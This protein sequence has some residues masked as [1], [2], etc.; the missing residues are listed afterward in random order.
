M[1]PQALFPHGSTVVF[2]HRILDRI[3]RVTINQHDA[4]PL[5]CVYWWTANVNLTGR[6]LVVHNI[7][8]MAI[9]IVRVV[10]NRRLT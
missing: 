2:L 10:A 5:C 6:N 8:R 4:F 3:P 7:R 9:L 1:C